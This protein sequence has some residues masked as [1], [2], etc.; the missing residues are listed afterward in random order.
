[1]SW[2]P[3]LFN[4]QSLS[5]LTFLIKLYENWPAKTLSSYFFPTIQLFEQ[6]LARKWDYMTKIGAPLIFTIMGTLY[7][8][9][10]PLPFLF[11]DPF[12][13][14]WFFFVCQH[15]HYHP[16]SSAIQY[17]SPTFSSCYQCSCS[18]GIVYESYNTCFFE[19]LKYSC[20]HEV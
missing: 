7:M 4:D 16:R 8:R 15:L 18:S 12:A 2:I 17:I 6:F 5:L 9:N 10:Y 14:F 19:Y 11:E 3:I 1:M 20:N 13:G